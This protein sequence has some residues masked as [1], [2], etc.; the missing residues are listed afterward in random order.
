MVAYAAHVDIVLR[1]IVLFHERGRTA[2]N[3]RI[4]HGGE[5]AALAHDHTAEVAVKL[6]VFGNAA[7]KLLDLVS[8]Q[9]SF[10]CLKRTTKYWWPSSKGTSVTPM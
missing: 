1:A 3:R 4:G 7:I 8:R 9:K 2:G 5:P 6:C 10:C